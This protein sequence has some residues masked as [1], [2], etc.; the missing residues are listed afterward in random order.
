M[1]DIEW[2]CCGDLQPNISGLLMTSGILYFNLTRYNPA[3]GHLQ[4][5]AISTMELMRAGD[6]KRDS[7]VPIRH[8]SRSDFGSSPWIPQQTTL[9]TSSDWTTLNNVLDLAEVQIWYIPVYTA[10]LTVH[11]LWNSK[12]PHQSYKW[13]FYI[14]KISVNTICSQLMELW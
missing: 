5:S 14:I 8:G 12:R 7:T 1:P 3:S 10:I 13:C 11:W 2:I 9:K 6:L 4:W